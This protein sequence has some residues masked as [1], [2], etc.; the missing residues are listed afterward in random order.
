MPDSQPPKPRLITVQEA[1][2]VLSITPWSVYRLLDDNANALASVYQGRRRY[3]VVD[4]LDNYLAD[5]PT[6]SP[7]IAS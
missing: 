7:D 3:V 4:S 2:R 1:A 5:L 6:V